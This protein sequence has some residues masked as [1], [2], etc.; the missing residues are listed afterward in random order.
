MRAAEARISIVL[1]SAIGVVVAATYWLVV[2][3]EGSTLWTL[4]RGAILV[5]GA[6]GC[7][8]LGLG[9]FSTT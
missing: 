3:H 2:Q 6:G 4:G 7:I 1:F 8:A 5:A 9:R